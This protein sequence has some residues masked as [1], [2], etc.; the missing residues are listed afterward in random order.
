MVR[1]PPFP[2]E[3][4]SVLEVESS[5]LLLNRSASDSK[6]RIKPR[7]EQKEEEAAPPVNCVC[8]RGGFSASEP[9]LSLSLDSR[10]AHLVFFHTSHELPGLD[11]SRMSV[12]Y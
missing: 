9:V 6:R 11:E 3:C 4:R 1:R 2:P 10:D 12:N 7:G 8:V 5:Q